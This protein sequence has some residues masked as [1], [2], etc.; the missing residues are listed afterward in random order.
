MAITFLNGFTI[1]NNLLGTINNPAI[2]AV[3]L[4]NGSIYKIS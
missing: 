4:Y 1:G 3:Q 2:S